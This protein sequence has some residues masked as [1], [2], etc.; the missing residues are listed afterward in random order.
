VTKAADMPMITPVGFQ[1]SLINKYLI[2][3]TDLPVSATDL[4]QLT[5]LLGE[6]GYIFLT[7]SDQI[8][9]EVVKVSG[10]CGALTVLRAQDGTTQLNFPKGSC[11]SFRM[12]PAVV[13]DM[14]CNTV[15]CEDDC[16]VPVSVAAGE[17][18]N[19][20]V[21]RVYTGT[22]VFSGSTPMQLATANV[23]AWMSLHI[24]ANYVSVTG[25]PPAAQVINISIAATNCSGAIATTTST[26]TVL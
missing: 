11:V 10:V 16:C 22:V 17:L 25:T 21:G 19:G 1:T 20:T 26:V 12:T 7:I 6:D 3:D 14:V 8:G 2:G 4:A 5:T 18:P 23:P 9:T 24:G 15:C 13:R